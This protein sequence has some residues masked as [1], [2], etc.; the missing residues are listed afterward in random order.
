MSPNLLMI[1][2]ESPQETGE[3]ETKT[4]ELSETK[5]NA[6]GIM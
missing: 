4:N 6:I 1:D 5:D 3:A 2:E